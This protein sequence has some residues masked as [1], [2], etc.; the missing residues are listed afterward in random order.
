MSGKV[1]AVYN[2][3]G[4]PAAPATL[5]ATFAGNTSAGILAKYLRYITLDV[6]YT[7]AEANAFV[8]MVTEVSDDEITDTPTNWYP[9]AAQSTATTENDVFTDGGTGMGTA[10]GIPDII[11]GDKTSTAARKVTPSYWKEIHNNWVRVKLLESGV[12]TTYGTVSV[13]LVTSN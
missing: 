11:P 13:Q 2:V 5:T 12:A 7:P 1:A 9:I 8:V 4:T 6:G 3:I 10:S